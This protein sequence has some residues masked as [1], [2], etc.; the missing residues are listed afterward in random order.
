MEL[1]P[2]R[3]GGVF[4]ARFWHWPLHHNVHENSESR[5]MTNQEMTAASKLPVK[6][7][8]YL[9]TQCIGQGGMAVAY[10]A[11]REGPEGFQKTVVLKVLL[12]DFVSDKDF[13]SMF[14]E[15]AKLTALLA[16]PNIVHVH[17]FGVVDGTPFLVMEYLRGRNLYQIC[18][19]MRERKKQAPLE[20]WGRRS[21]SLEGRTD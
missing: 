5:P 18:K 19:M 11:K 20:D 6:F 2:H 9:L 3:T 14:I 4:L 10:K 13:H 21:P 1:T 8:G 16:H 12:P 15:E 7:G 17:D